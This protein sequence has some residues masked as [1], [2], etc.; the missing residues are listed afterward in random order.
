MANGQAWQIGKPRRSQKVRAPKLVQRIRH[1]L[2]SACFRG[3]EPI[4][5]G[6]P[7]LPG[8][9]CASTH[10]EPVHCLPDPDSFLILFRN[11]IDHAFRCTQH[12]GT[13]SLSCRVDGAQ[14][15]MIMAD[16]GPG[17][18]AAMRERV[19]DRFVS[20]SNAGTPSSGLGLAIVKNIALA[21][22]ASIALKNSLVAATC[23]SKYVS[24]RDERRPVCAHD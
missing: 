20:W 14:A 8:C 22:G 4:E 16:P 3:M 24:R 1:G 6:K 11:V 10:N 2:N 5:L 7:C 19:F 12:P 13:V 17:I 23:W 21:Q 18:A 15:C 9:S